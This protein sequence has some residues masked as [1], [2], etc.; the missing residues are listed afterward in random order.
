MK[1]LEAVMDGFEVLTMDA[2]AK[3]GDIFCTARAKILR[4]HER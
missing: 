1:A 3:I 4:P 2:A